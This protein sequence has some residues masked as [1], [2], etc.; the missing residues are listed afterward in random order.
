[1]RHRNALDR[2]LRYLKGTIDLGLTYDD[3]ARPICYADASYGDD[4]TDRKSTYGNTLLVGNAAVTW[5]SKKQRTIASSTTEAEYVSMCQASKNIVW[6]TRFIKELHLEKALNNSPIQLLGDNQG[7][8]GLIE[9]PEHHS[10]T[11][12]IDVQYHYVREVTDD[13]LISIGYVP[14]SDMIADVLTKPTRMAVFIHQRERL[15]L[16]K[17]EF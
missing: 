11:K 12:H 4:V 10:R 16:T 9:N 13:G 7:A 3:S 6:A 5:A 17:V 2:V 8:L 15:G 1:M 14:T